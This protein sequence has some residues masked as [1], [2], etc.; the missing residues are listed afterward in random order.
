MPLSRVILG[1]A[2]LTEQ[3]GLL[4]QSVKSCGE[5]PMNFLDLAVRSGV[6]SFDTAPRY[7]DA[8]L[9]LSR[10]DRSVA[11]HTKLELGV[12]PRESIE[13]SLDRLARPSVEIAYLHDPDAATRD[14]G[15][16]VN[17]AMCLIGDSVEHLGVSVYEVDQMSAG[18]DHP[19]VSV[20]QI[21]IN[22]LLRRLA[23]EAFKRRSSAIKVIG[24]SI[25]AQGVLLM[26]PEH[27][28]RQVSPL[29][30]SLMELRALCALLGR[31]IDETLLMWAR[32]FAGLDGIVVGV[33]SEA[34][35]LR[36]VE[37]CS[38]APLEPAER[39]LID[40]WSLQVDVEIDPRMWK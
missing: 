26:E 10:I 12:S 37:C 16:A 36:L 15:Q 24:R 13:R 31:P 20:V 7:G 35:L 8:E 29:A 39:M 14:R 19:A 17:D 34:Q 22:P 25:F 9:L 18:F 33:A 38:A 23:D 21:P 27:L 11:I 30:N 3:Y 28:P 1:T 6:R 32:G 4:E 2:Q 5:D 40:E